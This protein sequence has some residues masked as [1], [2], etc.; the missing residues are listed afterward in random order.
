MGPGVLRPQGELNVLLVGSSDPRHILKTIS[1]LKD[2]D[3]LHVSLRNTRTS[4]SFSNRN[5]I[6]RFF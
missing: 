4:F 1:G 6:I 3:S 5:R 2:T